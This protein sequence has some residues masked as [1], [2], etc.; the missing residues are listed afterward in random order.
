MGDRDTAESVGGGG[1]RVMVSVAAWLLPPYAA[2]IVAVASAS[3]AVVV[4]GKIALV[5]P[6]VMATL[7]GTIAEGVLDER[8]TRTPPAGTAPV[9]ST[10]PVALPPPWTLEGATEMDVTTGART[11][12]VA[13]RSTPA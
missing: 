4:T 11:A 3:T 7:S 10:V 8:E 6:A 12:S 5:E 13:V 9:R 2:V 1:C